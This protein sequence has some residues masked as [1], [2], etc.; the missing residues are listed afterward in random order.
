MLRR[1]LAAMLASFAL[2]TL[3]SAS[4]AQADHNITLG[5]WDAYQWQGVFGSNLRYVYVFDRSNDATVKA[6]L[7]EF[8]QAFNADAQ[9]RGQGF[10]PIL[11]YY[12]DTANAGACLNNVWSGFSGYS[13]MTVC[14]RAGNTSTTWTAG[15][16]FNNHQPNVWIQRQYGDYNT[17]FS[18]VTHEL[19]HAMGMG[20]SY[21]CNTA[22]TVMGGYLE[23]GCSLPVGQK[24]FVREHDWLAMFNFYA[25]HP[26]YQ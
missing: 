21:S 22:D 2:F 20:H 1:F 19:L 4:P 23:A 10:D 6:A 15:G 16:H 14:A 18:H 24:L 11:M 12:D 13:F 9:R 26:V 17:T 25:Y 3:V 7:Q 5:H 8:T